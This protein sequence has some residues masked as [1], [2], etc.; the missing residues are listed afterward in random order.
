MIIVDYANNGS[1]REYLK[2]NHKKLDWDA[3]LNLATQ[4]VG[5]LMH[6]HSN[7]IVHG[8]LVIP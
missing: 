5:V 7:N 3:K 6:L 4:I 1:L 8:R 2:N